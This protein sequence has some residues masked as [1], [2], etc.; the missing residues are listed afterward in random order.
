LA[1][2]DLA[3]DT[4]DAGRRANGLD[5]AAAPAAGGELLVGVTVQSL[6]TFLKRSTKSSK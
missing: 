1:V 6:G 4:I 5:A 3:S 2:G